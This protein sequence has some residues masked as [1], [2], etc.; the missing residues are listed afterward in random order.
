[1]SGSRITVEASFG[2]GGSH[3]HMEVL[4]ELRWR[5]LGVRYEMEFLKYLR[6]RGIYVH[7]PGGPMARGTGPAGG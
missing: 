2:P 3:R 1:M 7:V 4:A 6:G 5:S